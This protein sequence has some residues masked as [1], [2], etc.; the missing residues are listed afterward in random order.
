MYPK[1]VHFLTLFKQRRK[2]EKKTNGCTNEQSFF[3]FIFCSQAINNHSFVHISKKYF[4]SCILFNVWF[5]NFSHF[6]G[7]QRSMRFFW[8]S[9]LSPSFRIHVRFRFNFLFA[10]S[11]FSIYIS[12]KSFIFFFCSSS[13]FSSYFL[14]FWYKNSPLRESTL[15]IASHRSFTFWEREKGG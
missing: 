6:Y 4:N 7:Y 8:A 5:P 2:I 11:V 14:S 10:L 15:Q 12:P 9:F 1:R 3:R 13:S